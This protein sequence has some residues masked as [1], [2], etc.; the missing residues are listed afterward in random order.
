LS[1]SLNPQVPGKNEAPKGNACH[2][3]SG[4]MDFKA[5]GYRPGRIQELIKSY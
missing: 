3:P 5:L 1:F 4:I 2:S